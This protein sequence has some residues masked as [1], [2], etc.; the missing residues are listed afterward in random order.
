MTKKDD[1]Y[2]PFE[3]LRKRFEEVAESLGLE[4][5]N[6]MFFVN[7]ENMVNVVWTVKPDAV[8]TEAER[9]QRRV[10]KEFADMMGGIE[11]PFE[12]KAASA[13]DDLSK[14]LEENE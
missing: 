7:E 10:D 12:D 1:A 4:V 14:W 8:M 11:D 2:R 13:R 9:D 6:M 3:N 5:H